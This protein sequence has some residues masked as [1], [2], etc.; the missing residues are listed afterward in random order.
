METNWDLLKFKYEVLGISVEDLAQEH[1]LSPPLLKFNSKDWK[2][3]PLASQIPL[4]LEGLTSLE[5]VLV[6]LGSETS[7]Q[8]KAFAILK[9]KFLGP[10]YVE[11]ETVLLH[12]AI[13][14]AGELKSSDPRAANIL[15][16]VASVLSDLLTHNPLLAP[17]NELLDDSTKEW[18]ITVVDSTERKDDASQES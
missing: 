2:Q 18:K 11:L 15:R 12:K 13:E 6:K 4:D 9:Q 14:M 17:D 5:D 10:K 16:S 3:I 7:S 8:T 1:S